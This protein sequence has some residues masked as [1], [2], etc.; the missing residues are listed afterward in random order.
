MAQSPQ[1]IQDLLRDHI[2]QGHPAP[3]PDT[4]HWRFAPIDGASVWFATSPI[5]VQVLGDIDHFRPEAIGLDDA[6]FLR[7][8]LHL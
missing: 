2:A 8:R 7:F 1:M 6:G 5:A 4:A 3:Q